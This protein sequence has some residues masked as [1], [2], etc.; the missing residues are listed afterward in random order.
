MAKTLALIC[1]AGVAF[2]ILITLYLHRWGSGFDRQTLNSPA[3][4]REV[5]QLNE[6]VTVRYSIEKVVGMQE[7]HSPVGTEKILLLVQGKVLAGVTLSQLTPNDVT[8]NGGASVKIHLPQ[9]HIQEAF[10][11]ERNT[12][13]WD[14]SITWWTPWISPDVNLEHR[15]R[16]QAIGDIKS[17]ALEMGILKQAQTNAETSI[18]VLLEAFGIA[19]TTFYYGS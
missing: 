5:R 3:V 13:V 16:M 12:R 9:P 18:R 8:L 2:L 6:L 10:I 1:L 7:E 15:A 17:A 19:N 11:D 4:V 14:R